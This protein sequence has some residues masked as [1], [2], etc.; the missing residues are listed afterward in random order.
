MDAREYLD[1]L[2][3]EIHAWLKEIAPP[4]AITSTVADVIARHNIFVLNVK[5]KILPE[6]TSTKSKLSTLLSSPLFILPFF[7]SMGIKIVGDSKKAFEDLAKMRSI[8]PL[9]TEEDKAFFDDVISTYAAY[10]YAHLALD[11]ISKKGDISLVER[12]FQNIVATLEGMPQKK[13][14]YTRADGLYKGYQ[15]LEYFL[16][17][18]VSTA[19][20]LIEDALAKLENASKDAVKSP[21]TALYIP[22]ISNE[23]SALKALKRLNEAAAKTFEVGKTPI[24]LMPYLNKYFNL[25]EKIRDRKVIYDELANYLADIIEA[26]VGT[27]HV[28]ALPGSGNLLIPFWEMS[29]TYTF[30]TGSLLW[31]KGKMV[32]DK[33]LVVATEPLA[34]VPWVDIFKVTAGFWDRVKGREET[35]TGSLFTNLSAQIRKTSI[36]YN[37]KVIPPITNRKRSEDLANYYL[38]MVIQRMGDKIKFGASEPQR[39]IYVPAEI[40]GDDV[41]IN[42]FG[43]SQIQLKPNLNTLLSVA[44]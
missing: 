3:G 42:A 14:E 4:T 33:L 21:S 43:E 11:I 30:A 28:E 38:D 1:K 32:E 12:N 16:S 13:V 6:F 20:P 25:T 15:A 5:P 17:G 9:V 35:L 27:G 22:A 7:T 34:S 8:E 41:Y 29:I 37:I 36:P 40:R 18:S 39:L 23:V 19:K 26:K 2:R 10:A 24:E 44:I 31:K